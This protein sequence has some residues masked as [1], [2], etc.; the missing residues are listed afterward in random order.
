M[1]SKL[2]YIFSVLF[3]GIIFTVLFYK[4]IMGIQVFYEEKVSFFR[5]HKKIANLTAILSWYVF[6]AVVLFLLVIL[7]YNNL[8]HYFR[9][10]SW[11]EF[12]EKMM[13]AF[14]DVV[15]SFPFFQFILNAVNTILPRVLE[16]IAKAV[17]KF[18]KVIARFAVSIIISIYL[19][20]D[21]QHYLNR[22]SRWKQTYLTQKQC[23]IVQAILEESKES[24]LAY[25]KGQ[26]LDAAIM[27]LL[28]SVGLF[29][30]R[31][32][33]SISIG[34]FAGI[35]NLIP[36]AGPIIA[37]SL[38]ALFCIIEGK[39]KTLLFAIIYLIVIQQI[40]GSYI[41]PKLLG[42]QVNIRSLHVLVAVLVGG[43]LFGMV[44]MIFAVPFLGVL[45]SVRKILRENTSS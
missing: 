11:E 36:Y 6:L 3:F 10:I 34:I 15:N 4:P 39:R 44:G 5:N 38:T 32:P 40:D 26:A 28:L 21:L 8:S 7:F 33:L 30:L 27:G 37:F 12:L 45:K 29:L 25:W 24:F 23:N 9:G 2:S 17:M 1:L 18:P 41:G 13:N 22:I 20:M 14:Y 31:V 19:L 16:A 35:G 42:R 43:T